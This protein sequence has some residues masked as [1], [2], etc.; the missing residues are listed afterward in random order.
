M[1]FLRLNKFLLLLI[2][3]KT[4]EQALGFIKTIIWVF[5]FILLIQWIILSV[6]TIFHSQDKPWSWC[7]FIFVYCWILLARNLLRIFDLSL[8]WIL[9]CHFLPL[10]VIS[11]S[12]FNI[13]VNLASWNNLEIFIF[14]HFLSL[15]RI[16]NIYFS[17]IWW[18]S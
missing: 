10:F 8:W 2:F 1:S 18:N 5:F 12:G 7:I 16:D 17:H 9:F 6:Q 11:L 15:C 13:T 4:Y 14:L 3:F